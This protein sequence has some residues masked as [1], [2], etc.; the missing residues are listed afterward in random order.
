VND[1]LKSPGQ[2]LTPG[3]RAFFEPRFGQD[4]SRVRVHTDSGAAQSAKAVDALAYTVGQHIVFAGGAWD[5][6][7]LKG[8][9]LLAHELV[10]TLQQ[11]GAPSDQA[12]LTISEPADP[13]ERN[14]DQVARQ[15]VA[16]TTPPATG[17]MHQRIALTPGL[18]ATGLQRQKVPEKQ[19]KAPA[20]RTERQVPCAKAQMELIER[21]IAD[22]K[23]LADTA[24]AA[25]GR[26]TYPGRGE[27]LRKHFGEVSQPQIEAIR[28][29]FERIGDSLATKKIN[30][31]DYCIPSRAHRI[32]CARGA[33]TGN[34]ILICPSFGSKA[35]DPGLTMVHEAAHNDGAKGDVDTDGRYP[36]VKNPEDNAYS[37]ENFA[38]EIRT[39]RADVKLRP[40]EEVQIE[41]PE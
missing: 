11:R 13:S 3:N 30:C 38:L 14:A 6:L 9:E 39:G 29:R 25:L 2:P 8:R 20:K 37:Y 1:V 32:E 10:H 22:G 36:P 23:A 34:V 28:E 40:K 33:F 5:P 26:L 35:C 27:A 31:L 4:F 7:T 17:T 12:P 16:D 19:N 24:A 41:V 15:L 18:P 21:G